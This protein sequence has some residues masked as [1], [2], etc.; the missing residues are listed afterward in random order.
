M[1]QNRIYENKILWEA[2]AL[3][4]HHRIPGAV[5]TERG[6]LIVYCE[7]RTA[8]SDWALMDI[9]MQRSTDG[10]ISFEPPIWLCEGTIRHNTVNNPVMI[11][12]QGGVLHLLYCVDYTVRG[13]GIHYRRSTDDGLTWS[14]PR[15]LSMACRPEF[16]QVLAPG[17]G[18][19]LCLQNGVLIAPVWMVPTSAGVPLDAHMPSVL[20]TIYSPDG[21][22]TW[23][24][25]ELVPDAPSVPSPNETSLAQLSDGRVMLNIRN[26][27]GKRAVSFSDNGYSGWTVPHLHPT[28]TDPGCYGGM[29]QVREANGVTLYFANCNDPQK[30][31]NVTLWE[32][33]NDGADWTQM[34]IDP[35]N[36]GSV[37]VAVDPSR[38]MLYLLYEVR[39]GQQMRLARLSLHAPQ[40]DVRNA[41]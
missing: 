25:G 10:G 31:R 32:S 34:C 16:H 5:V 18:H 19:G 41:R 36:G 29:A 28:L 20:T 2:D 15:D 33:G 13:G 12:G 40:T 22:D 24:M 26:A 23:R 17:P 14:V 35:D 30:R 38:N 39:G 8:C 9:L 1:A 6:T 21:G 4:S 11:V 3:Y 27:P 7:A 37:D